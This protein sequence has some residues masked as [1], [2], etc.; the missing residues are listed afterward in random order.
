[1]LP[2]ISPLDF[3][4]WG[5]VKDYVESLSVDDIANLHTMII[6]EIRI[7]AKGILIHTWTKLDY[8][9]DVIRTTMGF[10]FLGGYI[11]KLFDLGS[12]LQKT[13]NAVLVLPIKCLKQE[14]DFSGYPLY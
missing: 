13:A 3:F 5:F 14:H 9:L 4:L 11:H 12:S 10:P 8:E 2:F 6:E 7:V 1:M